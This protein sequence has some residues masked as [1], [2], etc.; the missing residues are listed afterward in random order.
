MAGSHVAHDCRVGSRCI[1]ANN[2]LLAGHC[3]ID[4]NV[5]ISGNSAIHQFCRMGRLSFLSGVSASTKDVPPFVMQQ[6]FN[7][8]VGINVVGMR[9]AGVPSDAINAV[10]RLYHIVYMQHRSVPNALA[11]AE[12][13]LGHFDVVREFID[14]VRQSRRGVNGIQ[15]PHRYLDLDMAA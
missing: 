15:G 3:E 1:F 9:R 7:R 12:S 2:A 11:L 8:V 14:F 13:E 10:R 6:N 5:Y 4:D